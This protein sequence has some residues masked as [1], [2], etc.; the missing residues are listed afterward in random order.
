VDHQYPGKERIP[1]WEMVARET[2]VH[3]FLFVALLPLQLEALSTEQCQKKGD[4]QQQL[5]LILR[6]WKTPKD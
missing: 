4:V 5:S 2:R 1:Y 3:R 6:K